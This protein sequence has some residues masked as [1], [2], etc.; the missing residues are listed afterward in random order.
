MQR[1]M[2]LGAVVLL[3]AALAGC[4]SMGRQPEMRKA[5]I[6]P[7][8]LKPGDTAVITVDVA[9]KFKIVD[10]VEGVVR[11][12]TRIKFRLHD[13][14]ADPDKK[15]GDGTWSLQVD[16]PFQAPPGQFTL[17]FTA[18]RSNGEPVVVR[19]KDGNAVPLTSSF[20]MVIRYPEAAPAAA[21]A[22][23]AK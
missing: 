12:D 19:D 5:L 10:H 9:D 4:H 11:E 1:F 21:G 2:L 8:N 6:T 23:A 3:A 20:D 13:D 17:D 18:Y 22:G 7:D 16:V 15:A 14:G